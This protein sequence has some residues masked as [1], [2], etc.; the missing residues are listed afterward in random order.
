MKKWVVFLLALF[1]MNGTLNAQ[2]IEINQIKKVAKNILSANV[3]SNI[4]NQE[5]YYNPFSI[6]DTVLF[7]LAHNNNDFVIIANDLRVQPI[8]GYSD[9]GSY[10]AQDIPP[11]LKV[12][13]ESYKSEIIAVKRKKSLYHKTYDK[14]WN[15]YLQGNINGAKA[16]VAPIIQVKWN[17]GSGWNRYCPE[18]ADG[19]G[20]R[21]YAGCVAIG[22][23]QA[24]SVYKHP[25]VGKG[26]SSYVSDY[27]TLTVNHGETDYNWNLMS[28]D[29]SDDYNALLIYH[30]AVALE[31]GFGPYGS[32]AYTKDIANALKAH[33]DYSPD[34]YAKGSTED[35]A[36]VELL[37]A[38]LDKG[39]PICYGGNNG[40]DVGHSFN[41]DGYNTSDAF[42][43]NWGW[44]GSY[45]GYFQIASLTPNG[46]DYSKN[47]T[48]VLN[49]KPMDHSPYDIELSV[50]DIV[51]KLAIGEVAAIVKVLDPDEG[52]E[53]VLQVIGTN[54][55]V[56]EGYCP[57]YVDGDSL[58]IEEIIEY[59][60]YRKVD[61]NIAVTDQQG[62]E[63]NKDFTISILKDN[64]APT[65]ITISNDTIDENMKI[66][67]FVG[68]FNTIDE[69]AED[70]FTY[71]FEV[72]SASNLSKD[73]NKFIIS[74][75]SLFTNYDF[76]TY[77][78]DECN[79]YIKSTDKKGESVLKSLFLRLINLFRPI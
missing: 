9:E 54:S 46:S 20:G 31:M 4:S 49:I 42:H 48:A 17:Q 11:Q 33:F 36:W 6:H 55:I 47:A 7:Y 25:D 72:N 13:L 15:N 39:R 69:D 66:G 76:T 45:N 5:V 58:K 64:Y 75:D 1:L 50:T 51:E 78:E 68:K 29:K 32:G 21:V 34:V 71:S 30:C 35:D 37:K 67:T 43:V 12:L 53:H 26:I 44:S 14:E 27:G 23:A 2:E 24:M 57:F 77:T 73:N 65:N 60:T 18:D 74:N 59:N 19:P 10:N 70:N 56:G 3:K 22:M 16:S 8:L 79:I 52:E 40:V 62:N 41:L 38:E 28:S 63:F 61:I